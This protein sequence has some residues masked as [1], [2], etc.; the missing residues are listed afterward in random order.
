MVTINP[1]E[2]AQSR[3]LIT[4]ESCTAAV[5]RVEGRGL[6]QCSGMTLSGAR[7]N[8]AP[9]PASVMLQPFRRCASS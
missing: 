1:E 6:G 2:P 7:E 3:R 8:R 9:K 5:S 4:L